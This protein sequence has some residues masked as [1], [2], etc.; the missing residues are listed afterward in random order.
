MFSSNSIQ[1][2]KFHSIYIHLVT[3][4]I[5]IHYIYEINGQQY[6]SYKWKTIHDNRDDEDTTYLP[7]NR[8]TINSLLHHNDHDHNNNGRKIIKTR[9][10]EIAPPERPFIFETPEALRTYLHKLNEYFAIIGRPRF[11]RRR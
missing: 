4:L 3:I 5:L 10:I 1:P 9:A 11:G 6:D 7:L 8:M 2:I